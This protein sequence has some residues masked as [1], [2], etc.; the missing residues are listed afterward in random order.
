MRRPHRYYLSLGSNIEPERNLARAIRRLRGYG[1]VQDTSG[2]WESHAVGS[3]GPDFLNVCIGFSTR[4]GAFELKREVV[5]SIETALGRA[6]APDKNAP[7]T[8]DIDIL[9][10]DGQPLN[11]ERWGHAFVVLPMAE[12]LPDMPHPISGKR[13]AE[14]SVDVRASMWIHRRPDIVKDRE[15]TG[16]T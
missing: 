16:G 4:V 7:R 15:E 9:M 12:L 10:Q 3:D 2:V 11:P 14:E 13:L 5:E 1:E 6:K 8:I